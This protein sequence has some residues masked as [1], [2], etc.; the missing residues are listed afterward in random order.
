MTILDRTLFLDKVENDLNRSTGTRDAERIEII[1]RFYRFY[2]TWK[3]RRDVSLDSINDIWLMS[4]HSK[5]A[6][7]IIRD[8][9]GCESDYE[10]KI[11]IDEYKLLN[12]ECKKA[13][14]LHE[15]HKKIMEMANKRNAKKNNK[16]KK[17]KN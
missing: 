12:N 5:K 10:L 4:N 9:L 3:T 7:Q 16:K 11:K 13:Y 14:E 2:K 15:R 17:K 6:W 8:K 1:E